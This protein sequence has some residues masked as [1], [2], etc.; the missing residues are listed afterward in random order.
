MIKEVVKKC[1]NYVPSS[2]NGN[3]KLIDYDDDDTPDEIAPDT[4][5]G[6][7]E[8]EKKGSKELMND[9]RVKASSFDFAARVVQY[10]YLDRFKGSN[11]KDETIV[12]LTSNNI[13]YVTHDQDSSWEQIAPG[14]E[15]LQIHVNPHNTNHVYLSIN[16]KVIHST[17]RFDN[18]KFFRTPVPFIQ[19]VNPLRFH[20]K[21]SN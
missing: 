9:G 7:K 6:E 19:R 8:N 11:S 12:F 14:E 5:S 20:P 2:D 18:W 17:N 15:I 4:N 16:N 10:V 3:N 21:H 1:L 13:V